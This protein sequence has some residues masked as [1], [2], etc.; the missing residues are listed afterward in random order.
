MLDGAAHG[1]F[2]NHPHDSVLA[3]DIEV[4]A[5]IR[6][7]HANQTRKIGRTQWPIGMVQMS[8]DDAPQ[9]V[10]QRRGQIVVARRGP[11]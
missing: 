8:Q 1:S 5:E 10:I 9:A 11:R 7:P 4:V 6:N 2:V 3:E